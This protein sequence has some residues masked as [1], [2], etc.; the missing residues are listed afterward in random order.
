MCRESSNITGLMGAA[1]Y[2]IQYQPKL[3]GLNHLYFYCP[4]LSSLGHW[5]MLDIREIWKLYTL[6]LRRPLAKIP[7]C[8][9]L[10]KTGYRN[11]IWPWKP[12][13]RNRIWLSNIGTGTEC[14][15]QILVP[16]QKVSLKNGYR[17][18]NWFD[19]FLFRYQSLKATFCSS[20]NIWETHSV[21]VTK[22]SRPYFVPVTSFSE[23]GA[24]WEF[25][26][27]LF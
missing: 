14:V 13:Y 20:T 21:L 1:K 9:S 8:P 18:K 2:Y 4:I 16:E 6:F 22:F 15:S 26:K 7:R 5:S 19:H 10:W 3:K 25:W 11:K 17:N 24:P 27:K 23:G 12:G